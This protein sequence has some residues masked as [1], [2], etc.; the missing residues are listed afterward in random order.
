MKE[1][2]G[3]DTENSRFMGVSRWTYE[4]LIGWGIPEAVA[5]FMNL[6]VLLMVVLVLVYALQFFVRAALKKGFQKITNTSSLTFFG[7][8]ARNRLPHYLA[9]AA[10][11]SLVKNAIPI[12]FA[13]FPAWIRPLDALTEIYMV[14]MIVWILMSII[15][16]G[17]DV[18]KEKQPFRDKPMESYLQVVQM[19]F[20][21]F[22]AVYLFSALTGKSPMVF[23]GAMG[24]ASAVLLL[25]FKDTIMGFVASIQVTTNDMVRIGDWIAMPKYGA[26]GDVLEINL[27]TVKVQNWDKTITTIPTYT[28]ISDS[29]QNWRGMSDSGGR[30]IKRSINIKQASIRYIADDELPRFK[31]IQGISSYIDEARD[32]IR[33]HNEQ[34][35]ADRHLP[36]NGRNLTNVGLFRKYVDWYLKSH[37]GTHKGMTM[38]V[39]QLAPTEKGMPLELYVFTNT[40]EWLEYEAVMADIFDHL[41]AAVKHFDLEIFELPTGEDLREVGFT[42]S[43][44]LSKIEN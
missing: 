15:K 34:I 31:K 26:D 32:E 19:V 7:Y 25:M 30:R 36:I 42:N 37:P 33:K 12:V 28:L 35:G 38:M 23:F 18:L 24:A 22:G 40:V 9:L 2:L 8:L 41:I 16:S 44:A 4:G 27:T 11:L 10:P 14:F 6:M 39:R 13:D 17:I 20:F 3:I 29:F 43:L 1:V 21:L 5:S